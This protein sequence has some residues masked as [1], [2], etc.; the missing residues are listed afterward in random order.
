M[1]LQRVVPALLL[2]VFGVFACGDA[3]SLT[4]PESVS[5]ARGGEPGRPADSGHLL[6]ALPVTGTLANGEAFAGTVAITELDQADGQLLVS[7]VLSWTHEGATVSQAFEDVPATLGETSG[8]MAG[9]QGSMSASSARCDILF[10]DIGPIFLDLLGL[11]VDLSEIVLDIDAVSGSGKLLGNLLCAVT[12]LLDGVGLGNAISNLLDRINDILD[13]IGGLLSGVTGAVAG[14]GTF[15]GD[16][17]IESVERAAG[18][19]LEVTGVLNGTVTL[20]DGTV[21]TITDQAFTA[22][23]TLSATGSAAPAGMAASQANAACG[24]LHL[25]LG[26]IFLDLLGLEVDLSQIVLD[27]DA[28][29][30]A[31]NLLGN[32]LCAVTGLLDGPGRLLGLLDRINDLLDLLG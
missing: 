10:L 9:F 21:Q 29:S 4:S 5:Y 23:G 24:I 7:G 19:A 2:V 12:G 13:D 16:V 22:I 14:G 27:I 32:L 6:S 3:E 18:G 28:V 11:E 30:G 1:R 20:A 17:V 31:G 15:A 26:P 25:D 8:A